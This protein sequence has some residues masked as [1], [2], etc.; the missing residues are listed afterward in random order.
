MCTYT[1]NHAGGSAANLEVILAELCAVEHRVEGSDFVHLHRSHL[2]D[3]GDLVHSGKSKEVIV[4]L[5][6]DKQDGD[7]AAGLVV[8]RVLGEK[9][10]NGSV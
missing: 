2:E 6:S 1:A 7:D 5:L 9:S 10:L 4:L 3:L 8:V